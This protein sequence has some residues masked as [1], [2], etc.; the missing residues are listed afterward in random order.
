MDFLKSVVLS[1]VVLSNVLFIK[2]FIKILY[3]H[4]QKVNRKII[5]ISLIIGIISLMVIPL[6]GCSP[7]SGE[8]KKPEKVKIGVTVA[9]MK[10]DVFYLIK[11]AMFDNQER[12]NATLIWKDAG[13]DE[14]RQA[15]HID[16]FI[17]EKVDVVIIH[18][19]N[20]ITSGKL[21]KKLSSK[22]IPVLALRR[23]PYE[24]GLDGY[25]PANNFRIGMEQAIYVAD[26][27]D[28][29]GKVVILKGDKKTNSAQLITWGN[30]QILKKE[31]GIKIVAEKWHE[32]DKVEE[33]AKT[34]RQA[35]EKY[36][37]I[38]AILANNSRLAM[39]AVKVLKEKN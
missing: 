6:S 30:K 28:H 29:E 31:P 24:V 38:K 7:A 39:Q 34:T 11:E 8:S 14:K 18:P 23:L 27:I 20:P 21:V 22:K 26:Q 13:Y 10:Y 16:E 35:L 36:P 33:A 1:S 12:E 32:F 15:Q 25:I 17:K 2:K 19:V 9:T 3:T 37:D 5:Y 4:Y